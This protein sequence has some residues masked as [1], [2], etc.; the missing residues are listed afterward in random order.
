MAANGPGLRARNG[1]AAR[2][3]PGLS[4]AC[5]QQGYAVGNLLA[6]KRSSFSSPSSVPSFE[7]LVAAN[8]SDLDRAARS[9]ARDLESPFKFQTPNVPTLANVWNQS[10]RPPGRLLSALRQALDG[11]WPLSVISQ[12]SFMRRYSTRARFPTNTTSAPARTRRCR[13]NALDSAGVAELASRVIS[14][15]K[16]KPFCESPRESCWQ[17]EPPRRIHLGTLTF[18]AHSRNSIKCVPQRLRCRDLGY[19]ISLARPNDTLQSVSFPG[20]STPI[21][22]F[23]EPCSTLV[24]NCQIPSDFTQFVFAAA[25]ALV[26]LLVSS[27]QRLTTA[28]RVAKEIIAAANPGCSNLLDMICSASSP[29]WIRGLKGCAAP[30]RSRRDDAKPLTVHV[31]AFSRRSMRRT[32]ARQRKLEHRSPGRLQSLTYSVDELKSRIC[33]TR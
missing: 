32:K 12:P 20:L 4:A 31:N 8:L 27:G 15:A 26:P 5:C 1:S 16:E 22:V 14:Y 33:E 10:G 23:T 24:R 21:S 18:P 29:R 11:S 9:R 7:R 13:K 19:C 28:G 25:V 6:D 2:E 17:T 30:C 3:S